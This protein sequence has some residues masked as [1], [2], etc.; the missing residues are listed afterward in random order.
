VDQFE[1]LTDTMGGD[2]RPYLQHVLHDVKQKWY[3]L[4]PESTQ[5]KNRCLRGI[6]NAPSWQ[7]R[8]TSAPDAEHV[9]SLFRTASR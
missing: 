8:W 3:A 5:G 6:S 4:I 7:C 1:V 2:I 9:R